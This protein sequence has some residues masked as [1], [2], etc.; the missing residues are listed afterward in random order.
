MNP[1]NK[2]TLVIGDK[3]FSSW[4][5]RAWLVASLSGVP[6]EEKLV[7]LD[8]PETKETLRRW[9]PSGKVPSLMDGELR[10]WDSLAI[11]EYFAELAP[12]VALWPRDPKARAVARAYAAEMHSSFSALRTH[13]SMDIRLKMEILH[14]T[15]DTIS[16]IERVLSLWESALAKS[17]GPFLFGEFGIVDAFYAPV[18]FRFLSYGI[19]ITSPVV[20]NYLKAVQN[21]PA[22]KLWTE[23]ARKEERCPFAFDGH[24]VGQI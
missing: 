5:M 6:F 23:A 20:L 18:V 8:K 7:F 24:P 15:S 1:D 13:L 21:F 10:I 11:A 14:L 4:S 17:E 19:H 9:S 3:N 2:L 16:E 22:V 12:N